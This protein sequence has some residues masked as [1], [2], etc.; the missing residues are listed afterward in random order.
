VGAGITLTPN[1]ARVLRALGLDPRGVPAEAVEPT[2]A[3]TGRRLARYPT[4]GEAFFLHRADLA[5][6][7]LDAARAAS[8][9]VRTD[10]PVREADGAGVQLESG[11]ALAADLVV[12]AGRHPLH[13]ARAG[14]SRGGALH[15]PRGRGAASRRSRSPP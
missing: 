13:L 11:E 12:G 15:G 2:D 6:L 1:G 14:V 7:L 5:S 3:L 4:R 8:V 10:A 9:A